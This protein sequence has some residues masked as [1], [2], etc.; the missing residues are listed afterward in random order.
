MVWASGFAVLLVG[1]QL[2]PDGLHQSLWYDRQAVAGGELWRLLSGNLVHLNWR[3]LALNVG[4]LAIGIWLFHDARTP[5]GWLLACLT[6]GL[7]TNIGL[8]VFHPDVF[9]CIGM[10]GA[11]HGLLIIGGFDMVRAGD[12]TGYALLGLWGLKIAWEQLA[13]GLPLSTETVGAPVITS[14]HF[15]GAV[16]GCIYTGAEAVQRIARRSV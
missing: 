16:G 8:W 2:L 3:H 6:C 9:W 13:G 11:L 7:A 5:W 12:R 4:A 10:S 14:A 1:L 15:W